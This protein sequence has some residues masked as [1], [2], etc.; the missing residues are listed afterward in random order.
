MGQGKISQSMV[1]LVS[2]KLESRLWKQY[3]SGRK[4]NKP[5]DLN[6]ALSLSLSLSMSLPFFVY[7]MGFG[8]NAWAVFGLESFDSILF[9]HGSV[10]RFF[11]ESTES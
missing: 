3:G 7:C 5:P 1:Q 4:K 6:P 8:Q 10:W 11:S 2:C 9:R